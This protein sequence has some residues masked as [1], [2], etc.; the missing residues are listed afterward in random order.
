MSENKLYYGDN[1]QVLRDH[2]DD[3]SVDLV[4]LDPPFNSNATYNVLFAEKN[5]TDSAAQIR[6]FDD[7]WHWDQDVALAYE[8]VI[9]MGGRVAEAMQGLRMFLGTNDMLAYL[10]MMAPR[11]VELRR[12]LKP[13]GSI[14]LHCDPTASHYLKMLMDSVFGGQQFRNELIWKRRTGSSSYVHKSNKFGVCTD[15][16]FFYVKSS[17]AE[18]H[19]QYTFTAPGYQDYIDKFFKH[20]DENG[21]RYRI[22]NLANPAPRPNLMY[23]YKGYKP[24]Q[25]GW[26]ISRGK[27]E[28]WD[29]EGRLH[30]PKNRGGRIQRRRFLDEVKG[31]PVQSLWDDI[32]PIG[33]QAAE[34][35]GYPT[36]KPEALLERV[37]MTSSSE[38]DV[39]L[40][41]F[42][43]CGTTVS[44]AQKL[45]RRWIGIDVTHLAVGLIKIRLADAFGDDVD[46][47]VHGEPVDLEGARAL[48]EAD[49]Y[50]FEH[51]ALGLVNAH[52][53]EKKKGADRGIDGLRRIKAEW[54]S[55]K[56]YR[57]VVFSVKGGATSVA[58]LRD[59]R[60][61]VD[62]EDAAVGVLVSLNNPTGPMRK[63]AAGAGFYT[64]PWG[65]HPR[66]QLL[67][68][69]EL[70]DGKKVDFPETAGVD[71]TFRQAPRN[72]AKGKTQQ[73][74]L[75]DQ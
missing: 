20:T 50:E 69:E 48:A 16:V 52:L 6:A 32:E 40:D 39:V 61:V 24:P 28:Q 60:G 38:D 43:G 58:H 53:A 45:G 21:R 7:T 70:L 29:R 33:A 13:T 66:L 59:L 35:L 65:Q 51:W 22:D 19:A 3:E 71:Q 37:I 36:Q 23:E 72:A 44:A 73:G 10:T 41:P 8:E 12:V 49:K 11:L 57:K 31:K 62:R 1:L 5:G 74:S 17:E 15:S 56:P 9:E 63:E 47:E 14:Y 46:Y 26:A 55:K 68:I 27:M 25:N 75:L 34:R 64:S 67:T 18:L 54:E 2:V 30:F 4:Y 42:C